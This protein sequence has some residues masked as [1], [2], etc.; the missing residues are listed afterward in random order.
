MVAVEDSRKGASTAP[1]D[2]SISI[3]AL[4]HKLLVNVEIIVRRGDR[5]LTIVRSEQE[6]YGGGWLCFPGGKL[7]PGTADPHALE[8]T[9][10]RELMEEVGLAVDIEDLIYVESHTFLVGDETVL[11]VV[12]LTESARGEATA[13]DTDEV[14]EILWLTEAEIMTDP[15]VQPF[16]RESLKLAIL[17]CTNNV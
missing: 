11:D 9:G 2:I 5:Y 17:A 15:R 13:I 16:T 1:T 3:G 12:L 10:Q 14:A 7:D 6:E 8:L 4:V